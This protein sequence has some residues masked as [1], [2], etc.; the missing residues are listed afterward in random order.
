MFFIEMKL[1]DGRLSLEQNQCFK[2][3]QAL[4]HNVFIAHDAA[5]AFIILRRE[6]TKHA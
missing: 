1:P 6:L 2:Q 4:G 3:L 5:E